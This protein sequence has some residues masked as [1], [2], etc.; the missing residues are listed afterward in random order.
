M[1]SELLTIALLLLGGAFVKTYVGLSIVALGLGLW[2]GGSS[3]VL[4]LLSLGLSILVL[5]A[6]GIQL[7]RVV[8][9]NEQGSVAKVYEQIRPAVLRSTTPEQRERFARLSREMKSGLVV[10]NSSGD[11]LSTSPKV[12]VAQAEQYDVS[13]QQEP[14]MG[15]EIAAFLVS[16]L[17]LAFKL[18]VA[19]LIPFL[20]LDLVVLNV[21]QLINARQ[22]PLELVS[23]PLKIL[24]FVA[25]DGWSLIVERLLQIS[26]N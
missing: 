16:E 22:V 10:V 1:I 2:R 14:Q 8:S 5:E 15:V 11:E 4:S 9:S 13:A 24:L 20:V 26:P 6:S 18:G 25:A 23:V 12:T 3:I 19:V 7:T 17:T 21:L